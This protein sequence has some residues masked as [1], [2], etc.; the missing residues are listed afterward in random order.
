[1][2]PQAWD[3]RSLRVPRF[4]PRVLTAGP[5]R[6]G[7]PGDSRWGAPHDPP[8]AAPCWQ[9]SCGRC[10]NESAHTRGGCGE[11]GTGRR[12][13]TAKHTAGASPTCAGPPRTLLPRARCRR[14][15]PR[16]DRQRLCRRDTGAQL[17]GTREPP[18]AR[19]Q[20]PANAPARRKPH[21]ERLGRADRRLPHRR[22]TPAA[23]TS[24]TGARVAVLP[25][26]L[27]SFPN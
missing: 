20:G 21:E 24:W 6:R 13:G 4:S 17:P 14:D 3:V 27:S 16:R 23:W 5:E 15:L 2:L 9:H 12:H 1:M 26:Q 22:L 8:A 11:P 19:G 10:R 18:C 7:R 25:E